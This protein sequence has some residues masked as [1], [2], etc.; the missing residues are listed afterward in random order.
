MSVLHYLSFP[1]FHKASQAASGEHS[2]GSGRGL[3]QNALQQPWVLQADLG[4][5]ALAAKEEVTL[6]NPGGGS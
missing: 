4:R 1:P 6:R 5:W 3:H 2:V